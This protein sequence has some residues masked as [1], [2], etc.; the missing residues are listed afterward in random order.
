VLSLQFTIVST[1]S[2]ADI[3]LFALIDDARSGAKWAAD[4]ARFHLRSPS[5]R[6]D[7]APLLHVVLAL[8]ALEANDPAAGLQWASA[9]YANL[10]SLSA[11]PVRAEIIAAMSA[12]LVASG[13]LHEAERCL[14]DAAGSP[15]ADSWVI[16]RQWAHVHYLHGE[17]EL[18]SQATARALHEMPLDRWAER[19]RLLNNRGIAELYLGK[20]ARSMADFDQAEMLF[21]RAGLLV[22]ANRVGH[23]R[24]MVLARVGDYPAALR[25]FADTVAELLALGANVDIQLITQAQVHL[26]IGLFDEVLE[27]LQDVVDRL[28]GT[29][30]RHDADQARLYVA[31]AMLALGLPDAAAYADGTARSMRDSDRTGWAAVADDIALE[32]R[33]V[34]HGPE[35]IDPIEA[36]QVAAALEHGGRRGAAAAGW[37]RAATVAE[38][39]GETELAEHALRRVLARVTTVEERVAAAEAR[40]HLALRAGHPVVAKGHLARGLSLAARHR[41]VFDATELRV[42]SSGWGDR[43]A[44]LASKL[45]W[46]ETPSK[47]L[48][49]SEKWR[50]TALAGRPVRPPADPVL[51]A[52]LA[53]L[54][55]GHAAVNGGLRDGADLSSVN[56]RLRA[57]EVAVSHHVRIQASSEGG[58]L[59]PVTVGQLRSGLASG[60]LLEFVECEGHLAVITLTRRGIG[61]VDLG[62]TEPIVVAANGLNSSLRRLASF[63]G[64]PAADL[65][66]RGA[67][68]SLAQ[69][70][71]LVVEPLRHVL[72]E[73]AQAVVVPV[74]ALHRAPWGLLLGPE[75]SVSIAASA[76][77]WVRFESVEP[78]NGRPV[79]VGGPGLPGAEREVATVAALIRGSLV[80]NRSAA[81]VAALGEALNRAS[82]AHLACHARIRSDS[83]LFSSVEMFDGPATAYDLEHIGQAPGLVVLSACSSG[84]TSQR[85][86]GE[87]LGLATVFLEAGTRA[88]VAA[89]IPLPDE[90]TVGVMASLHRSLQAG[91][92]IGQALAD[93]I[94]ASDTSTAEGLVHAAALSCFGRADWCPAAPSAN[95]RIRP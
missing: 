59:E 94:A 47:L 69:L 24:G 12:L 1:E 81:T 45:A 57:A 48:L 13:R 36:N 52:L 15:E 50:A 21:R 9:A 61:R 66:A 60:V 63:V 53:D 88:L 84:I 92:S 38:C 18:A 64:L 80:L 27:T 32:A 51:A 67:R 90:T 91:R 46:D 30:L 44:R 5:T 49:A 74:G 4:V 11:S 43:L 54:R 71:S 40:A 56:E 25:A 75:H 28:S 35:A 95:G 31:Q 2:A 14:R 82:I 72:D 65:V 26:S 10:H 23:N 17:M 62:P 68:A 55:A 70:T 87:V 85:T 22:P 73:H 83:P 3:P 6:A 86:H 7:V 29:G 34:T 8:A 39:H 42:Q 41:A 93:I 76:R 79:V 20:F 37:L 16:D 78:A 33:L 58:R 19:A 77:Q 89:T